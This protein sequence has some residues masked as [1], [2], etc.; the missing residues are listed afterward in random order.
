MNQIS[1]DFHNNMGF[2]QIGER[3]FD[4]HDVVYLIK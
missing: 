1:L 3:Q 2:K 4:D